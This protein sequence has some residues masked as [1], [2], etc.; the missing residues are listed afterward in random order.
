MSPQGKGRGLA[1]GLCLLFL[2]SMIPSDIGLVK[3]PQN[4]VEDEDVIAPTTPI[5]QATTLTVGSWPDGANERINVAVGDGYAIKSMELE[6]QPNTLQNSRASAMTDVGDFDDNAVYDG[7][8][9][10]KSSLQI[11]PQDWSYDFESGVFAPE[12]S[13]SGTSNGAI[14][15]DTR[16]QGAQLAKAGTITHNQESSM[17]LDV[18]QLPAASGT[19]R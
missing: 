15:A 16:L 11:L 8:D 18:S 4:L 13:L 10:N 2:I 6:L 7:M 5:G 9:V 1:I 17:T 3:S 12:W 14:R 19:F